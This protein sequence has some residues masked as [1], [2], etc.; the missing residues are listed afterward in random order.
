MTD[1]FH[2][3]ITHVFLPGG[4][5]AVTPV[6]DRLKHLGVWSVSTATSLEALT[7]SALESVDLDSCPVTN[8]EPLAT[9]QSLTKV[10]FERLSAVDLT[11]LATLPHLRDLHLIDMAEP[12]DLSALAGINHR[13]RL[14]LHDTATAGD[15]GSLVKIRKF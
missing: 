9:L 15:P 3:G 5:D 8:L 11:P 12:I 4:L 13:L 2:L 14:H 1:L 7:G 10:Q 6:L